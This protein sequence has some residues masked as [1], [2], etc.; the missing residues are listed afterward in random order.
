MTRTAAVTLAGPLMPCA[1]SWGKSP[2]GR[3]RKAASCLERPCEAYVVHPRPTIGKGTLV[4][5]TTYVPAAEK[6]LRRS[7]QIRLHGPEDFAAMRK[8]GALTAEALDLLGPMV[9]PGVTTGSL[10]RFIFE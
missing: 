4:T 8:A 3:R 2:C 5:T 1:S 7:G 9:K 6:A 10:D